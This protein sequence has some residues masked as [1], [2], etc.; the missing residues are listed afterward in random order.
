MKRRRQISGASPKR[1]R[2][3]RWETL[4]PRM[5][6][7]GPYAPA[8]EMAGST[9][10]SRTD[11]ALVAWASEVVQFDPGVEVD[12]D[13]QVVSRALGPA[14]GTSLETV[15][16][17][18]GGS[19]TLG[20]EQPIRDGLGFDFAVFENAVSDTFLELG[21]V[22]VSSDGTN[23][24]RF[25]SDSLTP[26][27]VDAFGELDPTN[28]RNLAGKYREGFGT[29]F[30]LEELRGVSPLLDTSRVSHVRIIDIVGDG[31]TKDSRGR[32]LYDPYPTVGSA[33]FD[34]DAVGVIRQAESRID[35]I[36]LEDLGAGLAPASAFRG[37]DPQGTA[38]TGPFQDSIVLGH[39]RSERLEFNNAYSLDY[40]SWNQW[41]YS[42]VTNSVTPGFSNQFGVIAGGGGNGTPTF[43]V[44]FV[45]GSRFYDPPAI[46][47]PADDVRTFSSLL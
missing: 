23:F 44:G 45:D 39:F 8:A 35:V 9:A 13:F 15:S 21:F 16:L 22:E 12:A 11:P 3:L 18:R 41:A 32:P 26:S 19:I 37:P 25:P 28:V 31:D 34:L 29:P 4:E 10:I 40:G 2:S 20:F 6:L 17:G 27:P 1:T 47:R 5:L 24:F 42:N 14:E 7:A 38:A 43:G 33:G 36:S 30:D 46:S